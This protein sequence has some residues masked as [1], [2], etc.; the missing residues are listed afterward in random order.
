MDTSSTAG[1]N[2]YMYTDGNPVRYRDP[3]GH[4]ALIHMFFQIMKHMSMGANVGKNMQGAVQSAYSS[5]KNIGNPAKAI[6]KTLQGSARW[7][8]E[9][10]Q[11]A[12]NS[13]SQF[14]YGAHHNE[15]TVSHQLA[16]SDVGVFITNNRTT[17]YAIATG[18]WMSP[19]Y[20]LGAAGYVAGGLGGST[21]THL[22][23][24][25][26]H[27]RA[28]AY[29][30]AAYGTY[31]TVLFGIGVGGYYLWGLIPAITE[32]SGWVQAGKTYL[33]IGSTIY[34]GYSFVQKLL[35]GKY[36]GNPGQGL[37]DLVGV[38]I[39]AATG[40]GGSEELWTNGGSAGTVYTIASFIVNNGEAIN[41]EYMNRL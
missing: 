25:E 40:I 21:L 22:D 19:T 37:A 29:L 13:Y 31:G 27:A 3:S 39:S 20:Q 16:R 2:L 36:D 32:F 5:G 7:A 11:N 35:G 38:G 34:S 33:T 18:A 23:W 28:G 8:S 10:L 4:N 41:R 26:K 30:G 24:S 17:L 14:V 6:S 1:M 15:N 9:G 12:A